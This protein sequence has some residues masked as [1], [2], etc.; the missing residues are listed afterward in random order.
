MGV[1]AKFELEG[2]KSLEFIAYSVFKDFKDSF[3]VQPSIPKWLWILRASIYKH[4][5]F[6]KYTI[7]VYIKS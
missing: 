2:S 1:L 6:Q 3:F 7:Y 4:K 5:I